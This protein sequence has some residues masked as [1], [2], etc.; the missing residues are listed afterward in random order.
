LPEFNRHVLEVLREPLETGRVS[1]ARARWRVTFPAECQLV[2]AMN[3]CPCGYAG[4]PHRCRC[5]PAEV[6]RYLSRLSGPFLDR[7]DLQVAVRRVAYAEL[8]G[9][10]GESTA[11]VRERVLAARQRQTARGFLNAR[12]P[13]GQLAEHAVMV[14]AAGDV[15]RLAA[16]KRQMSARACHRVLRVARTVAD[17]AG[18]EEIGVEHLAEAL[19]YRQLEAAAAPVAPA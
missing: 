14:P 19:D 11:A 13:A 18:K 9:A 3:P 16:A 10:A 15:L 2:A 6:R 8:S 4:E 5:L 7:I 1:L 12:L 17:L